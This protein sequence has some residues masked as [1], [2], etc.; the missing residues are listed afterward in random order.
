MHRLID[1]LGVAHF[2]HDDIEVAARE[3]KR[4]VDRPSRGPNPLKPLAHRYYGRTLARTFGGRLHV[5]HVVENITNRLAF[6]DAAGA[7]AGMAPVDV[8]AE[9][10]RAAKDELDKLVTETDRRELGAVPVMKVGNSPTKE[11]TQYAKDA[12]IDIIV[13]GATGRGVIDR[14]LM[15][16]VA[17]KVIRRAPCPVLTV[18][19]PEHE[20]I[21]PDA[22][23]VVEHA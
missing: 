8:Q 20:F 12:A 14:M 7:A 16:S 18:R 10:E 9:I 2:D 4:L 22:L 5:M 6:G 3:F 11:I 17:D 19:H 1:M 23:Q 21:I 15:G 13:M